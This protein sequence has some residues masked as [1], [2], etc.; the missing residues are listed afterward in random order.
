MKNKD[1][2]LSQISFQYQTLNKNII[3]AENKS[4]RS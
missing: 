4:N 2:N 1:K 3:V